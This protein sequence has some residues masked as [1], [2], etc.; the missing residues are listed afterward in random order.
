MVASL[1]TDGLQAVYNMMA[2]ARF[3][4]ATAITSARFPVATAMTSSRFT[5]VIAM[6]SASY[7]WLLP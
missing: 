5:V 3:T 2:C 7:L 1:I 6:T 4:V